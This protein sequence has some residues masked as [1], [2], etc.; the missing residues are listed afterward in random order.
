MPFNPRVLGIG[1]ELDPT[2]SKVRV[3]AHRI[4]LMRICRRHRW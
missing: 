1:D 2:P 4:A 3:R